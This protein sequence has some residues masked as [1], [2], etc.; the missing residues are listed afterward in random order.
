MRQIRARLA[1]V[2]P[3]DFL[4]LIFGYRGVHQTHFGRRLQT[5]SEPHSDP[6]W[7]RRVFTD[8]IMEPWGAESTANL[9]NTPL[10]AGRPVPLSAWQS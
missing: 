10:R 8:G 4:G 6:F 9:I 1:E 5:H 2:P 3:R 7:E